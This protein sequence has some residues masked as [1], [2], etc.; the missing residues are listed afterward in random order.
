MSD[1]LAVIY[2]KFCPSDMAPTYQCLCTTYKCCDVI[3]AAGVQGATVNSRTLRDHT[4][5]DKNLM[6]RNLIMQNQAAALA[7]QDAEVLTAFRGMSMTNLATGPAAAKPLPAHDKYSVERARR[8][9]SHVSEVKDDLA[10]LQNEAESIEV[11]S[12]FNTD[13]R[14]IQ[15]T[16]CALNALR[17][18]GVDLQRRLTMISRW[19]KMASVKSL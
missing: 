8:M 6:M 11:A 19:S 13:D 15:T 17:T 10:K 14:S 1:D 5:A 4:Q 7:K 18:S 9:V 3:N 12:D 2:V 16:L